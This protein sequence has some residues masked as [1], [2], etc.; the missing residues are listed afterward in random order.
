MPREHGENGEYVETVTPEDVLR[1]F[2]HVRGPVVL[3]TDV[4][5]RLDCSR[6]TARRKLGELFD[7]GDVDR[8]KVSRRVVYWRDDDTAGARTMSEGLPSTPD[9]ITEHRAPAASTDVESDVHTDG[10]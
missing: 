5:E 2:D 7:R 6:E 8:R 10:S 9:D 3:S 1:V 4:A